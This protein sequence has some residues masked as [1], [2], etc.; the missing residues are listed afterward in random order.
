MLTCHRGSPVAYTWQTTRRALAPHT[1]QLGTGRPVVSVAISPCGNFGYLGGEDGALEKFN[2]QS[3]QRRATVKSVDRHTGAVRGLATEALS[4][5]VFSGSYDGTIR[6]WRPADLHCLSRVDAGAPV[7]ALR[8]HRDSTLLAAACD[9]QC[10]RVF[11]TLVGRVV[12]ELRGHRN[13]ITDLAWSADGRWILSTSL[14]S[15][16]RIVDVPSG[17]A[18]GWYA[19]RTW[20][21]STGEHGKVSEVAHGR[22]AMASGRCLGC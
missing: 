14:D 22:A 11:D 15:T 6:T 16:I 20:V 12:R 3:G 7:A 5:C 4:K 2:L 9:D 8:Q 1:L 18:I 21:T 13:T 17:V 10:I 19:M